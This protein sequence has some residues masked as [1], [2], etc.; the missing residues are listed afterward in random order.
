MQL[1]TENN[2][3]DREKAAKFDVRNKMYRSKLKSLCFHRG[4]ESRTPILSGLK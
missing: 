3:N 2:I 4:K 1:E